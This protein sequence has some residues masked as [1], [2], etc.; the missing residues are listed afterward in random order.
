MSKA[1][2]KK[3]AALQ[4]FLVRY[5]LG[6]GRNGQMVVKAKNMAEAIRKVE[7]AQD[8]AFVYGVTAM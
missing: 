1:T 3:K 7:A 5:R 4:E 8:G 2:R 6:S